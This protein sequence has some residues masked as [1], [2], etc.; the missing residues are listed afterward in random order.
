MNTTSFLL[1]INLDG[2]S[3]GKALKTTKPKIPTKDGNL[4]LRLKCK[5][6]GNY[7]LLDFSQTSGNS[8]FD[9]TGV[10]VQNEC[11]NPILLSLY[12]ITV[13]FWIMHMTK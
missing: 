10:N 2:S 8:V 6:V 1:T 5:I 3:L 11:K 7:G 12:Y 9:N 13:L 4:L